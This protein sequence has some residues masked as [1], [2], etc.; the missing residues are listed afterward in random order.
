[1]ALFHPAHSE[2]AAL[3][4]NLWLRTRALEAWLNDKARQG[5][6]L[7]AM[8]GTDALLR[9]DGGGKRYRVVAHADAGLTAFLERCEAEGWRLAGSGEDVYI[10]EDA[11]GT[12]KEIEDGATEAYVRRRCRRKALAWA[13]LA[14]FYLLLYA[15]MRLCGDGFDLMRSGV[16]GGLFFLVY[17]AMM[18]A[19]AAICLRRGARAIEGDVRQNVLRRWWQK[20]LVLRAAGICLTLVLGVVLAVYPFPPTYPNAPLP[21]AEAPYTIENVYGLESEY[22]AYETDGSFFVPVQANYA[23]SR[24][25]FLGRS[26][27][28]SV[29][30]A[31]CRWEWVARRVF[32]AYTGDGETRPDLAEALGVDALSLS[33]VSADGSLLPLEAAI[34]NEAAE[35]LLAL[36]GNT[37][38]PYALRLCYRDGLRVVSIW[39]E[40]YEDFVPGGALYEAVR[41]RSAT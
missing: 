22:S 16:L 8:D 37:S 5:W 38:Y 9:Q 41:T 18:L 15:I 32:D 30:M 11:A 3:A 19:A 14:A 29:E 10:L 40:P 13:G 17:P 31:G 23:S 12:A 27:F 21:E 26:R 35:W 28:L 34:S 7:A 2:E 25:T 6:S 20:N 33:A 24:E 4:P 36:A 39:A 1:M